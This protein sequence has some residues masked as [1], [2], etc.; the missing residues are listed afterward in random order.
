MSESN[1]RGS[2]ADGFQTND[3]PPA[4]RPVNAAS[5]APMRSGVA[6]G[7]GAS[8]RASS[9]SIGRPR[10]KRVPRLLGSEDVRVMR[11]PPMPNRSATA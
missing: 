8:R 6:M 11:S 3:V 4:G 1:T 2:C 5:G 7:A 9:T 10:S